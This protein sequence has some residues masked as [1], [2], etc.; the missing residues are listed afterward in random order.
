MKKLILALSLAALGTSSALAATYSLQSG[1]FN[2]SPLH[3][4][5]LTIQTWN[6]TLTANA[7][8]HSTLV[9]TF[10][11]SDGKTYNINVRLENTYFT[12]GNQY[13]ETLSG[14]VTGNGKNISLNDINP[15]RDVTT[16]AVLGV[17]AAPYNNGNPG[18]NAAVLEF[19]FWGDDSPAAGGVR[20]SDVNTQVKCTSAAANA[21]GTCA[22]GPTN[23]PVPGSLALLGLGLVGLALRRRA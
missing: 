5:G 13:W 3:G 16:D 12:A 22:T 4:S 6:T 23:V 15:T 21:N 10:V 20:N 19:G 1:A 11:A 14:T 9:G 8:G 7:T 17:N 2:N 18:G